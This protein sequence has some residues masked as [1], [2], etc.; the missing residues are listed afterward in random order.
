MPSPTSLSSVRQ[1]AIARRDRG[2]LNSARTLL[3]R[4]LE[5]AT[6]TSGEDHPEVLTTAHLLASLH[7]Q[8]GDLSAARRVLENALYA[9]T[10]RH[11]EEHP[12]MLSISFELAEIAD[13]LGNRHEARRHYTRVAKYGPGAVSF[14]QQQVQAARAWLGPSAPAAVPMQGRAVTLPAPEP[15]Q[16]PRPPTQPTP[17]A[18]D[19][20]FGLGPAT[21]PPRFGSGAGQQ[22]TQPVPPQ[23]LPPQQPTQP[24]PT[25][26]VPPPQ[27]PTQPVPTRPVTTQPAQGAHTEIAP[28][29]PLPSQ[30]Q[31]T[32]P[33]PAPP[34]WHQTLPTQSATQQGIPTPRPPQLNP[35]STAYPSSPIPLGPHSGIP[36]P[37]PKRGRGVLVG[38]LIAAVIA[39][40]AAGT[41]VYLVLRS[42]GEI[43]PRS[44]TQPATN[45]AIVAVDDRVTLTWSD[46]S[47][48]E[49][50]PIIV[51]YR[52]S[53]GLRRFSVPAKG[54]TEAVIS[55]LNK[56]Y[57]YC[58][59]VV[60]VY[61][62]DDLKQSEQVCT[63]RKKPSP[64][65][66]R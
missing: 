51:G 4:A 33:T 20:D 14:N 9:G 37:R 64:S 34:A 23:P 22:T 65:P 40:L 16:M 19:D 10:N 50:Q 32:R 30:T 24:V 61:S 15:L 1:D 60:L 46:P 44:N 43:G 27:Q 36:G 26:P 12:L 31:Q 17:P 55:G 47:N 53:E 5:A 29:V 59:A 66:S 48:G 41:A 63:E 56:N 18:P 7:R 58:F 21:S 11:G 62:E 42:K 54:S 8:A 39:V 57:D 38:S 35:P 6:M 13:E 49:A 3:E 45:V 25:R 52:E 2:D 28:T